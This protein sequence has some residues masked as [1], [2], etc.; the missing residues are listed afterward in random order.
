MT[1]CFYTLNL[2]Y[3]GELID[4]AKKRTDIDSTKKYEPYGPVSLS[5]WLDK[6]K[7]SRIYMFEDE[8][9]QDGYYCDHKNSQ[10]W[11]FS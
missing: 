3:L 6:C 4:F 9:Q 7:Y 1:I 8:I 2:V 10:S 11:K 5:M